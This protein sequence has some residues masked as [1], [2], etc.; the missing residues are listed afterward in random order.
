MI[1]ASA[2]HGSAV[3]FTARRR[4]A[5]QASEVAIAAAAVFGGERKPR[6]M[7]ELVRVRTPP[8]DPGGS[9]DGRGALLGRGGRSVDEV[10]AVCVE[11]L[12]VAR[13][14]VTSAVASSR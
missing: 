5:G 7:L 11:L 3:T 4:Q 9:S 13:E 12:A 10:V 8:R 6:A 2:R 14:A 1:S